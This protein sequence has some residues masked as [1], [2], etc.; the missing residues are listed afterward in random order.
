M[1]TRIIGEGATVY[2]PV[3][4]PGALL[5]AGDLHAA[6]ACTREI[7]GTGV[8][9]QGSIQLTVDVRRDLELSEPVV[10]TDDVVAAVA[11][12][13]TL[14]EAAEQ[15]TR[16]M[17]D[18]LMAR[19]GLTATQAATLMSAAGQLQV[20]QI[21]D[22][23]KTARF[24]MSK[25]LLAPSGRGLLDRLRDPLVLGPRQETGRMHDG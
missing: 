24:S 14:D 3:S 23:L 20:S 2:F 19:L 1:D 18:L 25:E 7:C 10:E 15:A 8:E 16:H 12:A 13:E 9:I 22:P 17:A 6:M 11:S 21:V 4:A 5:S